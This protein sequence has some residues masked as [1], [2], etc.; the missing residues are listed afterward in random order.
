M[1]HFLG[2][3]ELVVGYVTIQSMT[4][5]SWIGEKQS[6]KI[7]TQYKKGFSP[8]IARSY[9]LSNLTTRLYE[10]FYCCGEP[11]AT[12]QDSPAR[13]A[14]YGMNPFVKDLSFSNLGTGHFEAGWDVLSTEGSNI[15]VRRDGL[16]LVVKRGEYFD[17]TMHDH[18]IRIGSRV[19][20]RY[21]KEMLGISPG[22]YMAL[23]NKPLNNSKD[24]IVRIYWNIVSEGAIPL[25]RNITSLLNQFQVPFNFKVLNNPD[26]YSTRC[27][28][29]VLYIRKIDYDLI[30]GILIEIYSEVGSFLKKRTPAFTKR[31]AGGLSLAEDPA[32]KESFGQDRCRL[33]ADGMIRAYEE[34]RKT[35]K[36][37]LQTVVDRFTE[38][39][40]N[41][42]KPYLNYNSIDSYEFDLPGSGKASHSNKLYTS[43]SKT[44]LA[45]NF[46]ST[47]AGLGRHITK[48]AIWKG[49]R[50]N[51]IGFNY[52][53]TSS[54]LGPDLYS[55][56][57][58]ISIFLARLYLVT[59]E[60]E[61]RRTA[62]G[63]ISQ[64][65]SS[66]NSISKTDRVGLYSGWMGIALATAWLGRIL[67][68]T[69]LDQALTL[70]R[71]LSFEERNIV[72][73]DIIS[74]KAG[75]IIALLALRK[76]IDVKDEF[77]LGL[78]RKLGE[79]L[80]ATAE[81]N[82]GYSW[83]SP[84]IQTRYNLTGFSH[85]A[86]GIGF[87]L[88]K[89]F[90]DTGEFRFRQAAEL[91][92][93]YERHYFEPSQGNWPDFRKSSNLDI[94]SSFGTVWCHGAP[95]IAI[96]RLAGYDT[97]GNIS[98]RD[99]AIVALKKT[100]SETKKM[101]NSGTGN[102]S[103]CHGLAGNCDILLYA[104]EVL[105][106]EL[107]DNPI[108]TQLVTNV[109]AAGI[110]KY[111]DVQVPWPCG[112]QSGEPPGLMIGLAGI[113][114]FYLRLFDPFKNPSILVPL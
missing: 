41:V 100:T 26:A 107:N 17:S 105:G 75:A 8:K 40:I 95:G 55:G 29:A 62:I 53:L 92:Y 60:E 87:S 14:L 91:A 12:F 30:S 64:A 65:L 33:L 24:K 86:A 2:Q 74:G 79:S 93:K 45:Q 49:D 52:D 48:R 42:E 4:A 76:T 101:L 10:N 114:Y 18:G 109:A 111:S 37:K 46:L 61:F 13:P 78:A 3:L 94:H 6:L 98:L 9:L 90:V 97:T 50:C 71:G 32:N 63:A 15:I 1:N 82:I 113:G 34:Q 96:S 20:I 84:D 66:L 112:V 80:L 56:T 110:E 11:T 83:K 51:W 28:T 67:D 25:M 39:G 54:A 22:F 38:E 85:G 35:V 68:E 19:S 108:D 88:L 7:P 77:L 72:R 103:L 31:L 23:G 81:S 69:F 59:G 16:H 104:N 27:D 102:F 58:G 57:S 47:A 44:I 73:A 36:E 5:Y 106:R 43:Y 89:L 70:M 21:P 99:E